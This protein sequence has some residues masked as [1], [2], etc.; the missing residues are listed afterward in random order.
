MPT[1]RSAH[2]LRV[3]PVIDQRRQGAE[4]RCISGMLLACPPRRLRAHRRTPGDTRGRR[5]VHRD[6]VKQL[7]LGALTG[8]S[9]LVLLQDEEEE[10]MP[11]APAAAGGVQLGARLLTHRRG[12]VHTELADLALVQ[13]A[14]GFRERSFQHSRTQPVCGFASRVLLCTQRCAPNGTPEHLGRSRTDQL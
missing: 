8:D 11:E 2:P 5:K 13:V 1:T 7:G 3:L 4:D 6:E 9:G 14:Q 12:R 10:A